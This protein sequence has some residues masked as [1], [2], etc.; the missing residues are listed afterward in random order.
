MRRPRFKSSLLPA[1]LCLA[2]CGLA[3]WSSAWGDA[4]SGLAA[5]RQGDY[6]RA[7]SELKAAVPA[8]RGAASL[9]LAELYLLTGRIEEGL[10]AAAN[11][12]AD[13][14]L[15]ERSLLAQGELLRAVGRPEDALRRYQEAVAANPRSPTARVAVGIQQFEMGQPAADKTLGALVQELATGKLDKNSSSALTAAA[16]AARRLNQATV[17]NEAFQDALAKDPASTTANLEWGA[18]FLE[19]YR[20]DEAGKCFQD[21]LKLNAKDPRALTGLARAI[22]EASYDV[23]KATALLS[24]ALA[25]NPRFVPALTLRAHLAMDDERYAEAEKHLET[26]LAANP[27]DLDALAHLAASKFLQEDTSGY[28]EARGRALKENPR[29]SDFYFIVGELAVRQHRYEDA[30]RLNRQAIALDPRN[31][32]ALAALATNLMRRGIAGEA[33]ALKLLEQAFKLDGFNVRTFNTLNLYEE[34]IAKEYVTVDAGAYRFRFEKK[35]RPLLERYV[36]GLMQRAWDAYVK[37]YGFTPPT[38]ITVELFTER[39]HYG[40]RTTGLPEIG[41]QGTCFG[42][43]ITAMSPS[44]AEASWELVLWHELAHVFHLQLSRNR[45]ARW[46]TEGLAEYETNVERPYWRRRHGAEIYSMLEAGE[47]WKIRDLSVAFVRPGR[48]NG[49]LLAYQQASLVIHYLAETFG[50]PKLVEA[51]KMYGAGKQ[52]AEIFPALTGKSLD[53][54]D[55]GFLTWLKKRYSYYAEGFRF[56]P[57]RYADL[58]KARAAANASPN[59]VS[60]QAVYAAA[61]LVKSDAGALGQAQKALSLDG[62]DALAR[63]VFAEALLAAGD[64][65]SAQQTY[66]AMLAEGTDGYPIRMRLGGMLM[67]AGDA[68]GAAAHYRAACRWDPDKSEPYQIMVKYYD[69]ND[70]RDK[71]L[72]EAE[73]LLDL[74]VHD[75]TT[76]RLLVDRFALDRRWEDLARVAPRVIS[77]TP[78]EPFVHQ[79]YG[80]ALVN[81]G[82]PAEAAYELESALLGGVRRPASV[83]ALLAR[84]YLAIG[85]KARARAAATQ[86][87]KDDPKNSEAQE[88]LKKLGPP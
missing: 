3:G 83:R 47:V 40:A 63:F 11:A 9:G 2:V 14:A 56:N 24:Q 73:A 8:Q 48:P 66:E 60:A 32:N 78:M 88:V 26:A 58:E 57:A 84:Q 22:I 45:V 51:L 80:R 69:D 79:E 28:E 85:D 38:P 43:L 15:K 62:M 5:L 17:A 36:P 27:A 13:P 18:L 7:E 35:E 81:L 65:G 82:K 33:E 31:A 29:F 76:A 86:A 68:P 61:M 25:V 59:D 12:A 37:K 41:A 44:A 23:P 42:T 34:V 50:F 20:P 64:A 52:D 67:R 72:R 1:A 21:V 70:E 49:V 30:V 19:K 4:A 53:E 46:F 74:E 54:L 10:Q 77:I 75:H 71:L 6:A 55:A 87:L 16:M 39:Q